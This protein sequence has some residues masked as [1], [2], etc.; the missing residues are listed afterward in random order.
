MLP[1]SAPGRALRTQVDRDREQER[2]VGQSAPPPELAHGLADQRQAPADLALAR[3]PAASRWTKRA[4]R[5]RARPGVLK[6][7]PGDTGGTGASARMYAR[8]RRPHPSAHAER[9]GIGLGHERRRRPRPRRA[10]V[11]LIDVARMRQEILRAAA[12][13]NGWNHVKTQTGLGAGRAQDRHPERRL[14][15]R[16]D[17][18]FQIGFG[19]SR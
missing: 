17:H 16:I 7:D 14:A 9:P 1:K 8:L 5:N 3:A 2:L 13:I 10:A 19:G 11:R 6:A 4:W 12:G 15:S 18:R